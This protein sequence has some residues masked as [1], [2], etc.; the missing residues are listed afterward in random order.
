MIKNT[1]IM[2]DLEQGTWR[3][4]ANKWA[5]EIVIYYHYKR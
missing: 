3:D 1:Y 4:R 2:D 5:L